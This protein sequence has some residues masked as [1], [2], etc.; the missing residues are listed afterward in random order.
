MDRSLNERAGMTLAG[1]Q[2]QLQPNLSGTHAGTL[3]ANNFINQLDAKRP[4]FIQPEIKP[5]VASPVKPTASFYNA[6]P[7]DIDAD[8]DNPGYRR[9]LLYKLC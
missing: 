1:G 7:V 5:R 4:E 3:Y 8:I 9:K 6:D 2:S